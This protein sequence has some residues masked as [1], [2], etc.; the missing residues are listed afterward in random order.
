MTRLRLLV[1]AAATLLATPLFAQD[2]G[3][4]DPASLGFSAERLARLD[5]VFE[6]YV[7]DGQLP[8]AVVLVARHGK[9]A[10]LAAYGKSDVEAARPM[11][12]DAIFRIAS[13][14]KA[15]VST[16][17][18]LL[19]EEGKLLV[20]DDLSKYLPEFA[21]TTVAE[22]RESDGR[23]VI[24][25]AKRRITLRDLLTHTSGYGYGWGLASDQ[26]E[27]AGITGWYFADRNE[28]IRETVRRMAALPADAH[29][30]EKFVYGYNT[31]ILGAVIEVA[32]GLPLDVFLTQRILEPLGMHDTHFYLP[33]AKRDR[34]AAVYSKRG[35]GALERAPAA[36]TME[37]QGH[38]VTGP[39]QSFSGGAGLLSTARDY[40]TFLQ[41]LANGGTFKGERILSRKSVELMH[42]NHL[43]PGVGFPWGEGLGFGLGF[44]IVEDLGG[45]GLPAS[46]GNY[47]WGGAYHSTYWID[48]VEDLVLVY[49]TQVI[50]A[51]NLDDHQKLQA[52]V[53]SALVD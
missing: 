34:L 4:A 5:A 28:P 12:T 51:D 26:W 13:Q 48:P 45:S 44:R 36:G 27:A 39:R 23:V 15:I 41:M 22:K 1:F 35:D 37:S 7:A 8:G 20:D 43:R 40:A 50:P 10:H 16:G 17:I 29:P 42:V 38:Y 30:G 24:V 49:F 21:E 19:Q 18:M 9:I 33:A 31:D 14:T 25:P 52:L 11:E 53:Y 47:G 2:L 6:D 32:S 3:P 46:L